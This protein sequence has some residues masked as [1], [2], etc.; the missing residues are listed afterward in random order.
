MKNKDFS[1]DFGTFEDRIWLNCAH[2]G[3]IP[4]TA[5]E[6]AEKAL[7][8]KT[9]PFYLDD[10][11]FTKIPE[12]LKLALGRLV[13]VPADQIILTNSTS[14]GLHLL[15]NGIPFKK[16]DEI[17]LIE[18]DFPANVLPWLA[19]KKQGVIVRFLQ[20]RN[21]M[22]HAG[23]I[24]EQISPSTRLFCTSWVNS[25]SGWAVDIKEIGKIC[26]KRGVIFVVNG[27]QALGARSLFI[28]ESNIDAFTCCGFKWLCGPYATGFSWIRP[29][30]LQYLQYNQAYWL[31]MQKG[32]DL[33][34][35]KEYTLRDD[36]GASAYDV[37]CTANFMNFMP[38]T[39]SIEYLLKCDLVKIENYNKMLIDIL[40]EGIDRDKYNFISPVNGNA[41]STLVIIS[42]KDCNKN[43][44]IFE[45][46]KKEGIDISMREGNLRISPH[47]Y[48]TKDEINKLLSILN[49]SK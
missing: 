23:E 43:K 5:V 19:L 10:E 12:R 45:T 4:N 15:A 2:Q 47:F 18:G 29:E 38:W 35:M 28:L 8:W 24:A 40:T 26:R 9:A 17:L 46:L 13:G 31:T 37:F 49:S 20:P 32:R 6:E 30:L 48:N 14:Y 22:P 44:Q 36:L 16:G 3:P 42:H 27:S 33:N 7:S 21:H 41:R 39:A 1:K 11:S 34:R 25:F